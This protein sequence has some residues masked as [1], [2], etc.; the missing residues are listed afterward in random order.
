MKV[1]VHVQTTRVTSIYH[2]YFLYNTVWKK[3]IY[4]FAG[5]YCPS[6]M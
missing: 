2:S 5:E 1:I 3:P 4:K 6:V